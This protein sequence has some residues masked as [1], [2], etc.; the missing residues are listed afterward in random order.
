MRTKHHAAPLTQLKTDD[1]VEGRFEAIVSVFSNVDAMG[2]KVMPG[3]FAKSLA[4]WRESGPI[5]VAWQ[6]DMTMPDIGIVEDARETDRGLW[7]RAKLDI[8]EPLPA[9]IFKR[10]RR[11][12][13]K[14]FSFAYEVV[15]EH[16]NDDGINELHEVHLL[17]VSPVWRGANPATELLAVKGATPRLDSAVASLDACVLGRRTRVQ[18]AIR[19]LTNLKI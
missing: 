16:M 9:Q 14:E 7:V 13:L 12:S 1:V 18:E 19:S 6:H 17:E 11:R 4:R 3:A 15:R 8:D 5:P 10:L 2:D